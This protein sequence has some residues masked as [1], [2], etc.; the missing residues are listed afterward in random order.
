M[1]LTE[2]CCQDEM[3]KLT[4]WED[5]VSPFFIICVLDVKSWW[6]DSTFINP[7]Q[8]F[9]NNLLWPMIIYNLEFPNVVLKRL[10]QKIKITFLLCFCITLRNFMITF[11]AGLISTSNKWETRGYK[12]RSHYL[13]FSSPFGVEDGF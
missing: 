7:S 3:S 12:Y 13:F 1:R 10:R 11:E 5:V 9:Y 2:L 6:D 4:R 8:Q